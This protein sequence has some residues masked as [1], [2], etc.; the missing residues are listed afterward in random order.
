MNY[1]LVDVKICKNKL[2]VKFPRPSD[3]AS[4][5]GD[6]VRNGG[7]V[8]KRILVECLSTLGITIGIDMR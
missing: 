4:N 1:L 8:L 2:I 3:T 7:N 6:H 5:A